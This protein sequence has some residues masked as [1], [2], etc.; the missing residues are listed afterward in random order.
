MGF[1]KVSFEQDRIVFSRRP[2]KI[3]GVIMFGLAAAYFIYEVQTTPV[4]HNATGLPAVMTALVGWGLPALM[5]YGAF[6]L[7]FA[8]PNAIVLDLATR[9]VKVEYPSTLLSPRNRVTP[10]DDW[11]GVLSYVIGGGG[12][13]RNTAATGAVALVAADGKRLQLTFAP[14][15]DVSV[16]ALRPRY[17]DSE[18]LRALR[19]RIA[20]GTGLR[21]LG[22]V[23]LCLDDPA[24]K[25][26]PH[27]LYRPDAVPS[28][29]RAEGASGRAP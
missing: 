28:D 26:L 18:E 17:A 14:A 1:G 11:A 7:L 8:M 12:D 13:R 2:G 9:R 23:E 21:D 3:V 19:E 22:F 15:S 27:P 16:T 5:I 24:Y 10:F 20:A 29:T 6:K 25:D 4:F